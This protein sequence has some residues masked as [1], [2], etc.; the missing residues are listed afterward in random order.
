MQRKYRR[1]EV[2][3]QVNHRFAYEHGTWPSMHVIKAVHSFVATA[4][5]HAA[6]MYHRY[7]QHHA[8]LQHIDEDKRQHCR[9][10]T[11][12]GVAQWH[13]A[14]LDESAV[15]ADQSMHFLA[16]KP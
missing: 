11:H 3:N 4:A 16:L 10:N 8:L 9:G 7:S 14:A 5:A 6:G 13:L 2:I 15:K 1:E 12:R